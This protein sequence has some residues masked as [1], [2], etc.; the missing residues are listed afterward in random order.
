MQI[1]AEDMRANRDSALPSAERP[2][3]HAKKQ[4]RRGPS[5]HGG[6]APG[7]PAVAAQGRPAG[8]P[9]QGRPAGGHGRPANSNGNRHGQGASQGGRQQASGWRP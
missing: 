3:G 4:H 8:A 2:A 6:G 7:K 5:R 1:P 9:H